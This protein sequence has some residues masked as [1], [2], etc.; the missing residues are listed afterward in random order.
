M[1]RGADGK[2][3]VMACTAGW[4]AG[5]TTYIARTAHGFE[6]LACE[7]LSVHEPPEGFRY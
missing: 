4:P 7:V 5:S 1:Q 6:V 3:Y 2:M